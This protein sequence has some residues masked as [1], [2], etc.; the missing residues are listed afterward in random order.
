MKILTLGVKTFSL[1][2]LIT[3]HIPL[4]TKEWLS[5][6]YF[7][8]TLFLK[9]YEIDLFSKPTIQTNIHAVQAW[10]YMYIKV[11]YFSPIN[12]S[13]LIPGAAF[14]FRNTWFSYLNI[15]C[16]FCCLWVSDE[17]ILGACL[18]QI[19]N[20]YLIWVL[21]AYIILSADKYSLLQ[22]VFNGFVLLLP[23]S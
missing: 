19:I 17:F 23:S 22:L 20:P 1:N 8:C 3:Q 18:L 4:L 21:Q 2:G 13:V 15:Q 14:Y 7:C 6:S 16:I 5:K 11:H 12:C 10:A 9:V